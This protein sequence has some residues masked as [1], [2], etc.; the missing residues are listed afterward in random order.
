MINIY[1]SGFK[2]CPVARDNL[3]NNGKVAHM[4]IP[5]LSGVNNG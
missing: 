4:V 3:L 2:F 5:S 1:R